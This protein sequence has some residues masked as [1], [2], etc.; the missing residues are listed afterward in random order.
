MRSFP[1]RVLELRS[2]LGSGGGPEKTI[3]LGALHTDSRLFD[4]TVCYLRDRR[5]AAF[6]V[7]SRASL[8]AD[9]YVEIVERHSFDPGIWRQLRALLDERRIDIIH[10]HCYKSDL[11]AWMASQST[12]ATAMATSHGWIDNT[13]RE[14]LLYNPADKRLLARFPRVVAVSERIRLELLRVGASPHNVSTILNGIDADAFQRIRDRIADARA[15]LGVGA[16]D[17][18]IGAVGRLD[19][20]KRF[21]LLIRAVA[22]LDVGTQESPVR[23]LIAGDGPDR[24]SLTRLIAE[25]NLE[26]RCHILGHRDDIVTL[27]HAFDLFVQSSMSEGT[28]NVV[29]EAMAMET[30]IVATDV[31]GT[32]E[33]LRDGVDGL[34]VPAGSAETLATAIRLARSDR[35]GGM[36]RAASARRRVESDLSFVARMRKVEAIYSDLIDRRDAQLARDGH[37]S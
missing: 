31:G 16:R 14:R 6:G 8:L 22:A 18:V 26:Q 9:R 24:P 25:L 19:R 2:V 20:G 35:V 5:D 17:F 29:L 15:S 32:R 37:A 12:R 34:L 36:A 28:P 30:P 13:T 27:H 1:I 7:A 21:D 4:V 10:S 3:I 33:L 11:L 23:L